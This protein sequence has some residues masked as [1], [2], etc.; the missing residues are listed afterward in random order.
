MVINAHSR[1]GTLSTYV[2]IHMTN[3][4]LNILERI[5]LYIYITIAYKWEI[6]LKIKQNLLSY[7]ISYYYSLFYTQNRGPI[8]ADKC[9]NTEQACD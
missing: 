6:Y 3:F 2:H 8:M 7:M 9:E 5:N 1:T 4:I